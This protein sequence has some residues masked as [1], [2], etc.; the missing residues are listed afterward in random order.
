MSQ[1]Q[2]STI[3]T[4]DWQVTSQKYKGLSKS[5]LTQSETIF[6]QY[7]QKLNSNHVLPHFQKHNFRVAK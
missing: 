4:Q 7:A 6:T 3:V 5:R 1:Y 2:E